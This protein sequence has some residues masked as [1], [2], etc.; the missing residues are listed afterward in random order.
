MKTYLRF[1]L[2]LLFTILAQAAVAQND[3]HRWMLGGSFSYS[4]SNKILS[5]FERYDVD[6]NL[7]YWATSAFVLG[8]RPEYILIKGRRESSANPQLTHYGLGIFGRHYWPLLGDLKVMLDVNTGYRYF[9]YLVSFSRK[10]K[11]Y[12]F[13]NYGVGLAYLLNKRL[14]VDALFTLNMEDRDGFGFSPHIEDTD[15]RIGLQW[16]L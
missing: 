12:Y 11:Y 8:L 5:K 3:A 9:E 6:I 16:R 4:H 15:L 2:L 7:A 1:H 14:S 13:A 10:N